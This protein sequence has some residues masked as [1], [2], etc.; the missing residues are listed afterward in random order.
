MP[1]GNGLPLCC[2]LRERLAQDGI[3]AEVFESGENRANL[4]ARLP[5]SGTGP[6]L[7][8]MATLMWRRWKTRLCGGSRRF[9]ARWR[10]GAC[11]AAAQPT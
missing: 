5:G 3:A 10:T 4:V 8:L 11:G 6:R 7:L 9:R 2:W 1:T